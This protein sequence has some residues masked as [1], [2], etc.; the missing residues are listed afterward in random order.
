[1][2]NIFKKIVI[3]C[4]LSA[5]AFCFAQDFLGRFPEGQ[6]DYVGGN[7][8]FYKEFH[9]ILIDK[10]IEPCENKNEIYSLRLLV[11][12]EKSI[13]YIKEEDE[14]LLKQ[15]KCTYDLARRVVKYMDNWNSA[16]VDGKKVPSLTSFIIIPD[17]LF[18]KFT[19]GYDPVELSTPAD[20]EGGISAFRKKVYQSIDL[21]RFSFDGIFKL[22]VT[23]TILPDGKMGDVELTESSGLPEFDKMVLSGIRSIRNK[24]T[25]AKIGGIGV[26]SKFRLPLNVQSN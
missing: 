15:N 23:F 16:T 18:D 6:N 19:D 25:P 13:K 2:E 12:E 5:F 26:S 8:A 20:Y 11:T 10:K 4:F 24:W 21:S 22:A 1:M 7:V 14:E 3:C 17:Q 9:Q